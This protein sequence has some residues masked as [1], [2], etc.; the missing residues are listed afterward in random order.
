MEQ[1]GERVVWV[2]FSSDYRPGKP[3]DVMVV[4]VVPTT[5]ARIAGGMSADAGPR[6]WGCPYS[7]A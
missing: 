5:E 1:L 2:I 3:E 4:A 7:P 6:I